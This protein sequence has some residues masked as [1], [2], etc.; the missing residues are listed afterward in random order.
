MNHAVL[1]LPIK[2]PPLN[3]FAREELMRL[4]R[5]L[6]L[7]TF[8]GLVYQIAVVAQ[9]PHQHTHEMG[10]KLGRVNFAT[11]CNKAAQQQFNRAVALLHSFWYDEAE[12][13]FI[14]VT[15]TDPNA[16]WAIGALP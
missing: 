7:A 13:A 10:E 11:S 3:C 12:K 4:N 1:V 15:R 8:A 9:T 14:Q 6:I 5:S 2:H 16:A